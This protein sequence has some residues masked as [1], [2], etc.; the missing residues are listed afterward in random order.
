MKKSN[1]FLF[2]VMLKTHFSKYECE[3]LFVSGET[4]RITEIWM[5]GS[6]S[7]KDSDSKKANCYCCHAILYNNYMKV[8]FSDV[9]LNEKK[10]PLFFPE[11]KNLYI[12]DE[13]M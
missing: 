3:I 9:I 1:A 8:L 11:K 4:F 7:V 5:N 6:E 12:K 10:F 13:Y 2:I